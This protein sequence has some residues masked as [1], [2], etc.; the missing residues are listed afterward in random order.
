MLDEIH[1]LGTRQGKPKPGELPVEAVV[2]EKLPAL[3]PEGSRARRPSDPTSTSGLP[4]LGV[5]PKVRKRTNQPK[6]EVPTPTVP[7]V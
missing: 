4:R 6:V 7:L 1:A 2:S 5:A 3:E